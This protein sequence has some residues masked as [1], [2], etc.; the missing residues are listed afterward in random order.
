MLYR[1]RAPILLGLCFEVDIKS[2]RNYYYSSATAGSFA[3][4]HNQHGLPGLSLPGNWYAWLVE[5]S[6]KIP[7]MSFF[8]MDQPTAWPR[9]TKDARI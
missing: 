6:S 5:R 1:C 7:E 4:P 3:Q 9:L 2:T 8:A